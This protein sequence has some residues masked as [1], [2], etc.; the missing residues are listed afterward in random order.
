MHL[1]LPLLRADFAPAPSI[2]E[3]IAVEA[4]VRDGLSAVGLDPGVSEEDRAA[5]ASTA[6]VVVTESG[7]IGIDIPEPPIPMR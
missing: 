5:C 2:R 3:N 6:F 4:L 7:A 1:D